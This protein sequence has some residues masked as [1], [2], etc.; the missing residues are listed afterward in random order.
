MNYAGH[1]VFSTVWFKTPAAKINTQQVTHAMPA[2]KY[3]GFIASFGY[4]SS[5]LTRT[6]MYR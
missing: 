4:F 3:V 5:I 1:R 6:A 2:Q